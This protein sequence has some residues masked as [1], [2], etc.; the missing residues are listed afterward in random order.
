MKQTVLNRLASIVLAAAMVFSL[1]GA[2][3][4]MM[5]R[6][7]A[8]EEYHYTVYYHDF[9]EAHLDI[10]ATEL[11]VWDEAAGFDLEPTKF[12]EIVTLEDGR[13]WMKAE[14]TT[15]S[16][17]IGVIPHSMGGWDWQTSNH[18]IDNTA[19]NPEVTVYIVYGDEANT[20]TELPQVKDQEK[21]YV[22]VEYIRPGN[23]YENWNIYTWNSG[24]GSA[25]TIWP[26][27]VNGK[28]YMVI[29]VVESEKEMNLGFC[30]RR[31]EG[32]DI[33]AEKDGG[34]HYITV[35]ADQKVVKA[36]FQQDV[37]VSFVQEYN[38]GF[39]RKSAEGTLSFFYRD[40]L[41]MLTDSQAAL[42]GNVFVTVNGSSHPM[43]YNEQTQ[44]FEYTLEN[45]ASGKYEYSYQIEGNTVLDPFNDE[46]NADGTAN[47]LIYKKS[48]D[49]T[50]AATAY[51]PTMDYDDNNVITLS[52]AKGVLTKE[53]I[54]GIT[55]DLAQ[56][57]LGIV[58]M[59]TDLME[60]TIAC[61]HDTTPG[62]K[63]LPVTVTDIYGNIYNVD[64]AV[65]VVEHKD[66]SFD[67]DEAVIY[68]TIT[69]RFFDGNSEN[70]GAVDLDG[71]LSYHGG[72]FA[73]LEA[74]LDYLQTLGVNTVWITP[75]VK[76]TDMIY[77]TADGSYASTGFHGYW[78]GDFT[79]LSDYLG[80]EEE[81]ESLIDALHERG[82]KLMVDVVLNHA[83]YGAESYFDSLIPGTKMIRGA[84]DIIAGSDVYAPLSGL[85]DF[86]TETPAVREKL[87]Q[88]QVDW[89]S[90]FD[91]DYY[92]VD[93]AK[94]VEADMLAEFK[95][96]LT[97]KDQDFKLIGEYYGAGYANHA[98]M[99]NSGIMDALL[100]F[101]FNDKVGN[102][103]GGKIKNAETFLG[104]RNGV[105]TNTATF[106]GFL[107][108]HDEDSFVDGLMNAGRTE[109]EALALAKVAASLQL[110]AK[111]LPVIY[112]GEEI[113]QHGLSSDYPIQS[114]RFDLNWDQVEAQESDPNSMLNHYRKVLAV[115]EKY[116][117][118]F[119]RA[120]RKV[121]MSSDGE[122]YD[123]IKRTYLEDTVYIALNISGEP[124]TLTFKVD[125]PAGT[126]IND[127]YGGTAYV[128]SETQEVTITIPAAADGGTVILAMEPPVEEIPQELP[129]EHFDWTG[130]IV[131]AAVAAVAVVAVILILKKKKSK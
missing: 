57:G 128:V 73:G 18:Y 26:E 87:I 63:I 131:A 95:N 28:Q 116:S 19:C 33:W 93:T 101:D 126:S 62:E 127:Q 108:S 50:L 56:L 120:G 105:L 130:V 17:Y 10:T 124:K 67:W 122:G 3:P 24:Y 94:H 80:T 38:V 107:S 113:G 35:P 110:T 112:Y 9:N 40:D 106:G 60:V 2:I 102:F 32:S 65:T 30:M 109:E 68:M 117:E 71:T 83:G 78:A 55:V 41:A 12:T 34:D 70:N 82:M 39:E 29:P 99:L 22:I 15:S 121:V 25:V 21:R 45:C 47:T 74:K 61:A 48:D 123:V 66:D 44:R 43:T 115:R 4:G 6:A 52:V 103:A 77:D 98:G 7:S 16:T 75:I 72:D 8:S 114:N 88:W 59:N 118:I 79:K 42:S 64:A 76:N 20:Y 100:D 89:V 84:A 51:Y 90:K 129:A 27:L 46:V 11:H 81:L 58:E 125:L 92:R 49:I 86:M 13:Q 53:E 104:R 97:K 5:L 69:D 1:F 54:S 96:E 23:D 36:V 111:G 91:I 119:A 37:G 85:P 14:F 31:S